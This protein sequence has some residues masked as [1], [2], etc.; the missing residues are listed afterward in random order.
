VVSNKDRRKLYN[1]LA[2]IRSERERTPVSAQAKVRAE[3]DRLRATLD[4][5]PEDKK[6]CINNAWYK[7]YIRLNHLTQL[8]STLEHE[9]L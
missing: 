3:M 8:L 4:A 1:L 5:I 9:G 2:R 6:L 7:P